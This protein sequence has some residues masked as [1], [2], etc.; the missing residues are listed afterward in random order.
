MQEIL[1]LAAYIPFAVLP[2]GV[3]QDILSEVGTRFFL[4][5]FT[6]TD[7][8]T[9]LYFLKAQGSC[10]DYEVTVSTVWSEDEPPEIEIIYLAALCEDERIKV[11]RLII[12]R[13]QT[14]L[15][16]INEI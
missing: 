7:E 10:C 9:E 4:K 3:T 16:R 13:I 12:E 15:Q 14:A 1:S 2:E 8:N 5:D 11:D 6:F